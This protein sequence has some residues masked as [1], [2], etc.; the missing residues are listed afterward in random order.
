MPACDILNQCGCGSG[1]LLAILLGI[2]IWL[3]VLV[4]IPRAFHIDGR[5]TPL[6][7]W[8][9]I[10]KLHAK[11][12]IEY[13]LF[14]PHSSESRMDGLRATSGV[15]GNGISP[16]VT[17]PL[18]LDGAARLLHQPLQQP[19]VQPGG[20]G[21]GVRN[22]LEHTQS[23]FPI[24]RPALRLELY[25]RR[26]LQRERLERGKSHP[27]AE[28]HP[29]PGVGG[30]LYGT[31]AGRQWERS[32]C[33]SKS[34]GGFFPIAKSINLPAPFFA[35]LFATETL[36]RCQENTIGGLSF[37]GFGADETSDGGF[38]IG[39]WMPEPPPRS[40]ERAVAPELL[41]RQRWP[42]ASPGTP[43]PAPPQPAQTATSPSLTQTTAWRSRR[44]RRAARAET[45]ER[46][47]LRPASCKDI[48]GDRL[49]L[50]TAFG[51]FNHTPGSFSGIGP[52]RWHAILAFRLVS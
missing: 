10:G 42:G 4:T 16:G 50:L 15:R 19:T 18:E 33:R 21:A 20:L 30:L 40:P 38:E 44:A 52:R 2:V 11:G 9:G 46:Q 8:R 45:K 1:T 3:G 32:R 6:L 13:P 28:D 47:F 22:G 17:Q 7:T 43:R 51:A 23:E 37:G 29:G 34:F 24:Q 39:F 48:L 27:G 5:S 26:L 31:R 35:P 49:R 36:S 12:G 41:R 14:A 25:G